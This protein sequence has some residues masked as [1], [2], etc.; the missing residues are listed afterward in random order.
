MSSIHLKPALW[1]TA[2]LAGGSLST[3]AGA[4]QYPQYYGPHMW[5]GGWHGWF[6]RPIM[7]IAFIAVVAVVIALL[8]RWL[9]GAGQASAPRGPAGRTP[10]D[11]LKE[12]FA[13]GEIDKAEFEER[14][15]V[16]GD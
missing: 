2:L 16:L 6:F 8:V 10:L 7:M 4:Q 15:R 9:G 13:R 5:D 14:R 12:R 11:I 3:S 1:A